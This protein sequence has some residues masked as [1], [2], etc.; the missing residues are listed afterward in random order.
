MQVRAQH[1]AP[2]TPT[3]SSACHATMSRTARPGLVFDALVR[4][5]FER[6]GEMQSGDEAYV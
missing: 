3:L 6:L 5:E 2:I 4:K 1:K